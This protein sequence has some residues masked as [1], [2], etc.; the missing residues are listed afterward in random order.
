MV[1]GKAAGQN[2]VE[3]RLNGGAQMSFEENE[4]CQQGGLFTRKSV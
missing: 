2:N 1:L 3:V 4:G